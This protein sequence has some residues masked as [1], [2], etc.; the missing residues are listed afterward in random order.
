MRKIDW[1]WLILVVVVGLYAWSRNQVI[2]R[3]Q[4][5]A[6]IRIRKLELLDAQIKSQTSHLG[7]DHMVLEGLRD[8]MDNHEGRITKIERQVSVPIINGFDGEF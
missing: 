3:W 6:N 8:K 1:L 5:E 4:S 7:H 2:N